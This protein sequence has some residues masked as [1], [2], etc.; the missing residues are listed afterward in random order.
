MFPCAGSAQPSARMM[1]TNHCILRKCFRQ[2]V[3]STFMDL[4]WLRVT[5]L[6]EVHFDAISRDRQ[7]QKSDLAV[8]L[9]CAVPGKS[10][11][12]HVTHEGSIFEFHD[13]AMLGPRRVVA[14]KNPMLNVC[15]HLQRQPHSRA[16][17]CPYTNKL[18]GV[19]VVL[20]AAQVSR[21][22]CHAK[23]PV[24]GPGRQDY[25][26][27]KHGHRAPTPTL[28]AQCLANTPSSPRPPQ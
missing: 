5:R 12:A 9:A 26:P 3:C 15:L 1:P 7:L 6:A 14:S 20:H 10:L 19:K 22:C 11:G 2:P 8:G 17:L 13:L 28:A 21:H 16:V 24:I 25:T 23:G 4:T 27:H 18:E